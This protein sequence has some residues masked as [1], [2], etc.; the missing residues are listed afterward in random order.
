M[1]VKKSS[2]I[3]LSDGCNESIRDYNLKIIGYEWDGEPIKEDIGLVL[4]REIK[5]VL[6][7]K[8]IQAN[9]KYI[10]PSYLVRDV[11]A[12]AFDTKMCW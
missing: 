2:V 6:E 1:K 12:N 8:G 3:V 5:G 9:V 7:K 10:D 11:P 4:K